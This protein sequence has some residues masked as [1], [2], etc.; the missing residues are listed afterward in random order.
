MPIRNWDRHNIFVTLTGREVYTR[1][2]PWQVHYRACLDLHFEL[3]TPST[4]NLSLEQSIYLSI[5]QS[6]Y[7]SIH[8]YINQSINRFIYQYL[9]LSLILFLP[10]L[11]IAHSLIYTLTISQ[12]LSLSFRQQIRRLDR[13]MLGFSCFC[14]RGRIHEVYQGNYGGHPVYNKGCGENSWVEI[15][16]ELWGYDRMFYWRRTACRRYLSFSC[17]TCILSI[18][19]LLYCNILYT[20]FTRIFD[21]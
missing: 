12:H 2:P 7:L 11:C 13:S 19:Q 10:L 3:L 21:Q 8:L 18:N 9:Y 6:V 4:L 5:N 17:I 15:S 16:G 20:S 14:R 1:H